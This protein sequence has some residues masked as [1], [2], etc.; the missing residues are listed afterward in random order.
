[1]SIIW[2]R[3]KNDFHIKGWRLSLPFGKK[4]EVKSSEMTKNVSIIHKVE[5]SFI[6]F[7]HYSLWKSYS[8]WP[9]S[10]S[11]SDCPFATLESSNCL[12][13]KN[14]Y[15][16]IVAL[17]FDHFMTSLSMVKVFSPSFVSLFVFFFLAYTDM[18]FFRYA[19][20]YVRKAGPPLD[21]FLLNTF[22][23]PLIEKSIRR[24]L[25]KSKKKGK[26]K[27]FFSGHNSYCFRFQVY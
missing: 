22:E 15:M 2:M 25:N 6:Y 8:Y 1:M 9:C 11:K 23:N 19:L 17:G 5:R 24:D 14:L 27:N 16:D 12:A 13:E 3:M 10:F 18:F 21:S 26:K 20:A 7:V 4:L